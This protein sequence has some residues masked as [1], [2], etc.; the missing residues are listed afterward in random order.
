MQIMRAAQATNS[1]PVLKVFT[2]GSTG[3]GKTTWAASAPM[4][5]FLLT[6]PQGLPSIQ[7]VNPEALVVPIDTWQNFK[8]VWQAV[9]QA[10]P[11]TLDN[12][13]PAAEANLGGHT[14]QFQTLVV[15][16]FT[17]L[18]QKMMEAMTGQKGLVLNGAA[19]LQLHQWGTLQNA[20]AKILRDQRH[21]PASTVFICLASESYD[22]KQRRRVVPALSGKM[23]AS[24]IG[25]YFNACAYVTL[26]RHERHVHCWMAQSRFVSKPAPG[27]PGVTLGSVHLGDLLLH[28]FDGASVA[29]ADSDQA[30]RVVDSRSVPPKSNKAVQ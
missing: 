7:A 16:S 27:F 20:M 18:Q 12:G 2:Y 23:I 10:R 29:H 19:Q 28:T 21:L 14:V 1:R 25:Q 9:M 30:S 8:Q 26:D 11:I 4:P 13:Q 3:L 15:D 17:D 6:E 22:E 24:T 5:L